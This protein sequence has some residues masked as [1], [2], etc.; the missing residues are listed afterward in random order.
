ML[1]AHWISEQTGGIINEMQVLDFIAQA[2]GLTLQDTKE[3]N[4]YK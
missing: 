3:Q 1:Q 2:Q 4:E